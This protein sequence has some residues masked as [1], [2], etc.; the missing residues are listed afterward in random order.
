M[1]RFFLILIVFATIGCSEKTK[2]AENISVKTPDG[3]IPAQKLTLD[4]VPQTIERVT[5]AELERLQS[6]SQLGPDFV[7]S[8]LPNEQKRDLKAYDRAFRAWQTCSSP[9]HTKDQV[10]QIIGGYLGNKC[11]EDFKMEWV[12]VTDKFGTEYAVRSKTAEI[13]VFPFSTVMKRIED[14]EYDFLYGVYH[15]LKETFDSG[16]YKT[17]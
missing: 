12:T 7:S 5:G 2:P 16:D 14:K 11:A 17:R 10:I 1:M 13:M 9:S 4:P 15:A 6:L 3:N 8:Y